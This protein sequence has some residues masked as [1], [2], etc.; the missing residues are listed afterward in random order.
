MVL[1]ALMFLMT[2]MALIILMFAMWSPQDFLIA[3]NTVSVF[4]ADCSG[5]E[6]FEGLSS[7]LFS[8]DFDPLDLCHGSLVFVVLIVCARG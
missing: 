7:L 8:Y 3:W 4:F 6:C 2:S 5:F 1:I